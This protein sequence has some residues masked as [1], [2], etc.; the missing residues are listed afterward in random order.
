MTDRSFPRATLTTE[1]L[2][3]QPL[4][5]ADAPDVHTVW[6]D[7]GYLRFAP[8]GFLVAGAD[9]DRAIE[10]CTTGVEERRRAGSGVSFAVVPREGSRLIGLVSLSETDW[11]AMTTE[12]H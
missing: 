5:P 6:N 2:A 9:L 8:Q 10:W 3:L 7:A 12:I 4:E 1:R 11:T